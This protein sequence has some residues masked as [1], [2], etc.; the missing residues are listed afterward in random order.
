MQAGMDTSSSS[1]NRPAPPLNRREIVSGGS[2]GKLVSPG[3]FYRGGGGRK[4]ALLFQLTRS[5][6]L[7]T[8]GNWPPFPSTIY[9]IF[10]FFYRYLFE[11]E[12]GRNA[13][14]N[15]A[16]DSMERTRVKKKKSEGTNEKGFEAI[17]DRER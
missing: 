11:E 16:I 10:L 7:E 17:K 3:R 2:S 6:T 4:G 9:T 12:R 5:T 15:I 8:G 1:P 13:V 14:F